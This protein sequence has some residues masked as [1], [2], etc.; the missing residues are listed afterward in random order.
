MR[1]LRPA[2]AWVQLP[3]FGFFSL[4]PFSL[5]LSLA[6][7][8]YGLRCVR[9]WCRLVPNEPCPLEK[10]AELGVLAYKL[11]A[12][13]HETDPRLAAIRKVRG[14]TYG[15]SV[16]RWGRQPSWVCRMPA[17]AAATVQLNA[18]TCTL[19]PWPCATAAP[20]SLLP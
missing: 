5:S 18:G 13:K 4:P 6:S 2:P 3:L 11:D 20:G 15:V 1:L 10:L 9:G 17:R 8:I 14:Y 16:P 12:D 19:P 7:H